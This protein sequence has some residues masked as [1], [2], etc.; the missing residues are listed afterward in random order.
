MLTLRHQRD[1][2]KKKKRVDDKKERKEPAMK[3]PPVS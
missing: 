1:D 3:G 2:W